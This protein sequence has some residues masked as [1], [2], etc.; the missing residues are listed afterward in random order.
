MLYAHTNH[1]EDHMATAVTICHC[2]NIF[3]DN[4]HPLIKGIKSWTVEK[5]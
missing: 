2:S 5:A 4:I 3:V 1:A